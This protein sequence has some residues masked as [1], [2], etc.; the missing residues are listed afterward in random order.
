MGWT[1]DFGDVK[2]LF[3]PIFKR[4]DHHPLHELPGLTDPDAASLARWIK[5]QAAR[6]P[7]ADRPHRPLRDPRLRRHPPGARLGPALPI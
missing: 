6:E 1:V 3:D 2:E 5:D 7:A 4:I